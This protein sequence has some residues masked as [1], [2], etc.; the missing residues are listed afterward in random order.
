MH[1]HFSGSESVSSGTPCPLF[2]H[3]HP[4]I[5]AASEAVLRVLVC[6]FTRC[7][8]KNEVTAAKPHPTERSMLFQLWL[9]PEVKISMKGKC[10]EQ[11]W[12]T[13]AAMTVQQKRKKDFQ[14]CF[15]KRQELR[16]QCGSVSRK[17]NDDLYFNGYI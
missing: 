4:I 8:F 3:T 5:G 11:I 2:P 14:N 13:E 9:F 1:L 7:D 6:V 17:I 10:F 12:D 16:D 15:G